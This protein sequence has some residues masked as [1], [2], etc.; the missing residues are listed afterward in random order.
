MSETEFCNRSESKYYCNY[1]QKEHSRESIS[2]EHIIP[3]SFGNKSYTLPD[4]CNYINRIFAATFERDFAKDIFVRDVLLKC[5]PK[6]NSVCISLGEVERQD[7]TIEQR[8]LKNGNEFLGSPPTYSKTKFVP[9][10]CQNQ[11]GKSITYN[12]EL[13]FEVTLRANGAA[14][15]IKEEKIISRDEK[16]LKEY[17]KKLSDNP[18][19][20][21]DFCSFIRKENIILRS[22]A[23]IQ[24]H[25]ESKTEVFNP[26]N[27]IVDKIIPINIETFFQFFAKIAWTH[28]CKTYN[29]PR[30]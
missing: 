24:K 27:D 5:L 28:T 7:G 12:L 23:K 13:P 26:V 22:E 16:K 4:V 9:L 11:D 25:F 3:Q 17:L 10:E 6:K 19:V 30:R 1:C 2:K 8:W 29:A 21:A 15:F 18:E 20:N 14:S